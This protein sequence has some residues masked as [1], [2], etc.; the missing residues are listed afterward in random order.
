MR[1]KPWRTMVGKHLG[2]TLAAG[3]RQET[4]DESRPSRQ[5]AG[6]M[7]GAMRERSTP[8]RRPPLGLTHSVSVNTIS[9][10]QWNAVS[11]WTRSLRTSPAFTHAALATPARCRVLR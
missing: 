2:S 6:G 8:S 5:Q 7:D 3:G 9:R 11:K 10:N 4:G 1:N